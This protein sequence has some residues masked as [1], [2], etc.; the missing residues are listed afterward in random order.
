MKKRRSATV[1]TYQQNTVLDSLLNGQL[2]D[3]DIS[4]LTE[5]MSTIE[6][7]FLPTSDNSASIPTNK[8]DGRVTSRAGFHHKSTRMTLLQAVKFKPKRASSTIEHKSDQHHQSPV[9]PALNE[10]RMSLVLV[11]LR[12]FSR[13]A[14]R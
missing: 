14:S 1:Q 13:L 5:T 10:M 7:L 4:S 8:P 11:L 12:T 3:V 6:G 2:E 9:L